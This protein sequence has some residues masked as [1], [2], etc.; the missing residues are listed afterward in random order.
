MGNSPGGELFSA[1][2]VEILEKLSGPTPISIDDKFWLELVK[3]RLPDEFFYERYYD[4]AS[5]LDGMVKKYFLRL[6]ATNETSG[7]FSTFLR[8]WTAAS[9]QNLTRYDFRI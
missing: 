4:G 8:F 3:I 9:L 2:T 7:N 5:T 6:M 1:E